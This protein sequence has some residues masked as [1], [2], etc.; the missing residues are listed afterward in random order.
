[1]LAQLQITSHIL[2]SRAF[3]FVI[4]IIP[5][6]LLSSLPRRPLSPKVLYTIPTGQNPS[7]CSTSEQR[8][9]EIYKLACQYNLIILEDDPYY[10]LYYGSSP[11]PAEG[12]DESSFAPAKTTSYLSMDTERRYVITNA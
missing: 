7:G 10:N 12:K 4:I 5:C 2:S 1:M 9:R 6:P 8:K 3:T 11:A